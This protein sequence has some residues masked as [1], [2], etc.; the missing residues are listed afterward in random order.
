MCYLQG[1]P[2]ESYNLLKETLNER[3]YFL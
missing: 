1:D 3:N 2:I